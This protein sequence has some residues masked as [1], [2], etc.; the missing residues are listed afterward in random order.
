MAMTPRK[1]LSQLLYNMLRHVLC[2]VTLSIS[3]DE[4]YYNTY[5]FF[6]FCTLHVNLF[7][8]YFIFIAFC[9][10]YIYGV[11]FAM[12]GMCHVFNCYWRFISYYICLYYTNSALI[13]GVDLLHALQYVKCVFFFGN[14][15]STMPMIQ[16]QV[17]LSIFDIL[18]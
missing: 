14:V 13:P 16:K 6:F 18:I 4:I 1:A 15:I 9:I 11:V 17:A 8:L 10:F 2:T 12:C 5:Y 7:L 3:T